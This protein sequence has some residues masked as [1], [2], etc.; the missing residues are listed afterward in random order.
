VTQP[1]QAKIVGMDALQKKLSDKKRIDRPMKNYLNRAMIKLKE[2]AIRRTPVGKT[3]VLWNSY[4]TN[5]DT[6]KIEGKVTNA[7]KNRD[8][9]YFYGYRLEFSDMK[10]RRRGTIPFFRPALKQLKDHELPRFR[11]KL[12]DEIESRMKRT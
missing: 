5:L 11:K 2:L 6:R 8:S 12:K 4:I 7:A 3:G 10:A 1:L 9:G